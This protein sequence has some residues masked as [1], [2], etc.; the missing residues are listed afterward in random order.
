MP[1]SLLSQGGAS[2]SGTGG[3]SGGQEKPKPEAPG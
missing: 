3:R 1:P 2:T